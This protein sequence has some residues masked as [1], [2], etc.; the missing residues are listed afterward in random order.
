MKAKEYY[1]K[2][3]N[4]LTSNEEHLVTIAARDFLNELIGDTVSTAKSRK[5]VRPSALAAV[6]K[7]TNQKY[8]AVSDMFKKEFGDSPLRHNG[9][10]NYFK[11][12][13]PA[14]L[15]P[16]LEQG[17]QPSSSPFFM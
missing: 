15:Q 3:K 5:V 16:Y 13:A 9:F 8:N 14:W 10:L 7:E 17:R 6:V 4:M 2:Y 1:T 11:D 12:T